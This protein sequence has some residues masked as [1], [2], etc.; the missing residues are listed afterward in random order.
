MDTEERVHSLDAVRAFALLSCIVLHAA[1]IFMPGLAAF[2]F[3]ADSSQSTV[4][5]TVFY[6][7]HIFRMSLFFFIG[8]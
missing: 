8:G 7:I 4:L 5:Q 6:V 3:P 1:M 2:G